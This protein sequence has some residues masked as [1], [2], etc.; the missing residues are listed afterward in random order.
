M[1]STSMMAGAAIGPL[2]DF[3]IQRGI[4][5]LLV[6]KIFTGLHAIPTAVCTIGLA[7]S[8][9]NFNASIAIMFLLASCYGGVF[10]GYRVDYLIKLETS[11]R[12]EST[13]Y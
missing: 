13:I 2:S 4:S 12:S 1:Y 10:A 3:M 11:L 6:R 8:E 9:D 5:V 7:Y